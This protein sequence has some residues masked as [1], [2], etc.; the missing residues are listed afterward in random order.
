MIIRTVLACL[1]LLAGARPLA[2]QQA[3]P[4][5]F[6]IDTT[7]AFDESV[8]ETGNFSTGVILDAVISIEAGHGFE[9]I[10]R[11]FAQRLGTGEW[12][13]QIWVAALRY[14]RPGRVAL[15][16]DG[17][18]IPPPVGLANLMLR[19][20]LNPVIA[21]PASLFTA[22]P[23]LV[24]RA[25]RTNL[26][27]AVYPYGVHATLSGSHWDARVAAIDTSPLR[28]RR[29]F[30]DVNPPRFANVVLGGGITP[31][32]GVRVG[33]SLTHGGWLRA[34]ESPAITADANA[35]VVTV[36]TDV[37]FRYTRLM[38][39]WV[40]DGVEINGS[41]ETSS[42][43]FVQ[44]Q[45]TLTP[46]WFAA[47]RVERMSSPAISPLGPLERQHFTGVEEAVGFRVT[48]E[49]TIRAAHRARRGFG[50]PEYDNQAAVSIVWWKR[51]F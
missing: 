49:I 45:Q 3:Q 10:V 38:A 22:L 34:G 2:A 46:R 17:G 26:L 11:P 42:G 23:P 27:G 28:V 15:R 20:H 14:Q 30:A 44:G 24:P 18:L 9:G 37:Q 29:V 43:W 5:R 50:R 41:N 6:A 39:E 19:P 13:R 8:D 21:Q 36:E 7:A 12:N 16:V 40:R 31:V 1:A 51:W 25:P 35:T 48:P 47:A 32:V 4:A 33:A